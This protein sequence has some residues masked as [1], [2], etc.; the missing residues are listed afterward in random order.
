MKSVFPRSMVL[1]GVQGVASS[2]PAAPTNKIKKL[3]RKLYISA[4]LYIRR[5]LISCCVFSFSTCALT[6]CGGGSAYEDEQP[7]DA[8]FKT[9]PPVIYV[10]PQAIETAPPAE[11]AQ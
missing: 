10:K 11:E 7:A 6:G 1:H 5:F 4:A 3:Q 8:G 9:A 2:N